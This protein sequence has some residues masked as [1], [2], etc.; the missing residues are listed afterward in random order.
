MTVEERER[1]IAAVEECG[2]TFL[3]RHQPAHEHEDPDW[4]LLVR[5]PEGRL[6]FPNAVDDE[7]GPS[8]ERGL[9]LAER[10]LAR[11]RASR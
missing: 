7:E 8:R 10:H 3:T 6:L 9:L 1:R 2:Y 5:T 4:I 11:A